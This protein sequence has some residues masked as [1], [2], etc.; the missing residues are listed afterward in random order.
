MLL[1]IYFLIHYHCKIQTELTEMLKN[2]PNLLSFLQSDNARIFRY[3]KKI[4]TSKRLVGVVPHQRNNVINMMK[5]GI[6][7]TFIIHTTLTC[8]IVIV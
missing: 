1:N 6:L 4:P 5:T 2:S 7:V 8:V 3:P